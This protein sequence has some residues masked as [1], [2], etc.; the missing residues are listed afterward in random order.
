M[1]DSTPIQSK[2]AQDSNGTGE[3][4]AASAV[5][6]S[7]GTVQ[8]KALDNQGLSAVVLVL[9]IWFSFLR[10][11]TSVTSGHSCGHPEHT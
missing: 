4:R 11:V 6:R 5:P 7:T 9:L 10:G 1:T 3:R 2:K 8:Q